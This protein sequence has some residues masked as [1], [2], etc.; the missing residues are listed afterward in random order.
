MGT[1]SSC[2]GDASLVAVSD[3]KNKWRVIMATEAA[4]KNVKS[5]MVHLGTLF[6][7]RTQSL[8]EGWQRYAMQSLISIGGDLLKLSML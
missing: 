3:V 1:S 5:H 6:G 8:A 4:E 2:F 7:K